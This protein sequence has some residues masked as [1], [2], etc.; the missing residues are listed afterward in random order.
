MSSTKSAEK[1]L[2]SL[3]AI[4]LKSANTDSDDFVLYVDGN[5]TIV[6]IKERISKVAI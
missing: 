1:P 5:D 4:K 2:S 3:F 6:E